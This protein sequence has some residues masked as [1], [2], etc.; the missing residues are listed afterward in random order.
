MMNN[1]LYIILIAVG[2]VLAVG[3]ILMR[4]SGNPTL[5]RPGT[6][7]GWIGIGVAVVGRIVFGRRRSG[8]TPKDRQ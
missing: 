3:G 4:F 7:L 5:Y 2:A 1:K 6:M 8:P